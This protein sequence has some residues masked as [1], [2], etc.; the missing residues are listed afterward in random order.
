MRLL[1]ILTDGGQRTAQDR[2]YECRDC[3]ANLT[4]DVTECP[5][6][7]GEMAVYT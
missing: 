5:D 2:H 7:G 4:P 6:C 3:G 1:S